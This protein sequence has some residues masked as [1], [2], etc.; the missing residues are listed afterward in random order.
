MKVQKKIE[1]ESDIL[2][3][4]CN[5]YGVRQLAKKLNVSP[6]F[7][8]EIKNNKSKCP[9]K[10]YRKLLKLLG[11]TEDVDVVLNKVLGEHEDTIRKLGET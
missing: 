7:I 5:E 3:E 6:S 4:A 2:N 1:F 10:L 9:Y 11:R 8:S